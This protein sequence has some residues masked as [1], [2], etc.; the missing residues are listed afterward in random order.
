LI[1]LFFE[2]TTKPI[3]FPSFF[4]GQLHSHAP[5]TVD[6]HP[7]VPFF[8]T[9][10]AVLNRTMKGEDQARSLF[11]ISLSDR[12]KWQQFLICSSGFFFGYLINGVCEVCF[13]PLS[14]FIVLGFSIKCGDIVFFFFSLRW[15]IVLV[16]LFFLV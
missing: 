3:S 15:P 13:W 9:G 7:F 5:L 11:G 1:H 14:L 10:F 6:T 16:F 8:F 4:F 2:S 12:P